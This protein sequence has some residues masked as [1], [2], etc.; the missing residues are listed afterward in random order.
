MKIVVLDG[1]TLNPGDLDWSGLQALGDCVIHDRT[2]AA[3]TVARSQN[4]EILLTNKTILSR[5]IIEQLPALKYISILATGLNVVDIE[6][7]KACNI[8]VS[9]VPAYSTQ[10]VAQMTI[11]H[12]L[13]I[14]SS[15]GSHSRQVRDGKWSEC[16]DF[17]YWDQAL[18]ELDALTFGIVGFGDI[19]RATARMAQGFGMK[20]IA[21]TRSVPQSVPDGVEIVDIDTVFATSDVVSLHCPLTDDNLHMVDAV[22]LSTMKRSAILINTARGPLVDEVAL[23]D[24][25]SKGVIA[26][27]GLDVL[28]VEPP[29]SDHPL[30]TVRNCYIT[31]HIGWA[32]RAARQR[33]MT[34]TVANVQS[35]LDGESQ[36]V[37]NA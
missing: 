21:C 7:A 19:G 35:F 23:A 37:V 4:V 16:A 12:L 9:N 11:A 30:S 24:A 29:V 15:V 31:P 3:E 1:Y 6:A 8:M 17:C 27:S 5:E 36:N 13:N 25:L 34:T 18:I 32:T 33:L 10:S 22:R 26:A 2:P 20:V 14:T 28:E